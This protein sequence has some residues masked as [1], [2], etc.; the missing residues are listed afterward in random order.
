MLHFP[1]KNVVVVG[2]KMEAFSVR[3]GKSVMTAEYLARG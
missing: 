3:S 2:V 1:G